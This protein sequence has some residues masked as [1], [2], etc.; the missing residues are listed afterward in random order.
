[1]VHTV[2][3]PSPRGANYDFGSSIHG[4]GNLPRDRFFYHPKKGHSEILGS[5]P[6]ATDQTPQD[7]RNQVQAFSNRVEFEELRILTNVNRSDRPA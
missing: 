2:R 3:Y 6:R 5:L 7:R 1:M 4:A